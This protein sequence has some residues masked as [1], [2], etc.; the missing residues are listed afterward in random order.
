MRRVIY[1][2]DILMHP[3]L[4]EFPRFVPIVVVDPE[5]GSEGISPPPRQGVEYSDDIKG[6]V[7]AAV[8]V[9]PNCRS[10]R[11]L[12]ADFPAVFFCQWTPDE[13]AGPR[14]LH[15]GDLRWGDVE[16]RID[17]RELVDV[18]GKGR[19]GILCV[20]EVSAEVAQVCD[21]AYTLHSHYA[22][23][24]AGRNR[25]DGAHAAG[26]PQ[27]I[28]ARVAETGLDPLI[29]SL[30]QTKQQE[31][32]DD[33]QHGQDGAGLLAPQPCPDEHEIFHAALRSAES[34]SRPLS[35]CKIREA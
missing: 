25:I 5:S 33:R 8:I 14:R 18:G 32:H 35:T 13:R 2:N 34:T 12:I 7:V 30:Q 19:D 22:V 26:G 23:H 31:C 9:G 11:N 6:P 10:Q 1:L 28:V 17:D 27:T 3:M 29:D 20:L 21:S 24:E 16:F 15:G 4:V